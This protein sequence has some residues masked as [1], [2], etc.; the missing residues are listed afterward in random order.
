MAEENVKES[1]AP[2]GRRVEPLFL[3]RI[4]R[5]M[6]DVQILRESEA[7]L[8]AYRSWIAAHPDRSLWQST[9]WKAY[10]EALGREVRIYVLSDERGIRASALVSIDRTAG[11]AAV[12]EIAHGPL[13]DAQVT[14]D[15]RRAF[16]SSL[17]RDAKRERGLALFLSPPQAMTSQARASHRHVY[18]EATRLLD[19]TQPEETILAGMKQKGR[20]NI[21]VAAKRGV[22][23]EESS[24]TE[25][26][27]RLVKETAHRDKF[28]I[29]SP[30]HYD[31]FLRS[32]PGAFLLLAYAPE[33][34]A[35][36]RPI[37]GL[38]GVIWQDR[39]IYYY[40]A[41]S[42]AHRA[43]MAPYLLQ[44]EAMRL[45]KARGCRSYDL[46][47]I[48]PSGAGPEHP[49][50]G[51][52]SFKEKFGG[53]EVPCPLERMIVLRPMLWNA[54]QWKRRIVG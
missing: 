51:I 14:E 5:V 16:V 32:L 25:A 47:G 11:G 43:H 45:C 37:A 26:F 15:E 7:N 31:V 35:D 17:E 39:G 12:W 40:G 22:R 1:A 46:F 19:L 3:T 20:Y 24:D 50:A 4:L 27:H 10:Q 6:A 8:D 54:L 33:A 34:Q 21:N 36:T 23:I 41:S 29:H 38:L 42:Y 48:A 2:E 30:G 49:W 53:E 52:T 18:P 13:W 28:T 44:W 9:E